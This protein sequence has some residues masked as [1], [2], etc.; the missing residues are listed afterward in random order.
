[1]QN[2][3]PYCTL[4]GGRPLNALQWDGPMP[5]RRTIGFSHNT[6]RQPSTLFVESAKLIYHISAG[7]PA[8]RDLHTCRSA[9]DGTM[10]CHAYQ[11]A[12]T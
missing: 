5:S 3:N 7:A 10:A 8:R 12:C 6:R 11:F 1:M 9:S 2:S 4:Q